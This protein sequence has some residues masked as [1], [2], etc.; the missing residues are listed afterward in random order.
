MRPAIR[1]HQIQQTL[2]STAEIPAQEDLL[3]WLKADAIEGANDGDFLDTWVDSS[4]NARTLS[5]AAVGVNRPRYNTGIIN[6]NPAVHFGHNVGAN[7][8]VP[9]M[10]AHAAGEIMMIVQADADPASS[11]AKSGPDGMNNSAGG[12]SAMPTNFGTLSTRFAS[13]TAHSSIEKPASLSSNFRLISIIS[14]S[15]L[16]RIFYDGTLIYSKEINTVDW[17]V[18]VQ[19]IGRGAGGVNDAWPG[20]IAEMLVWD[21]AL[22]S[23]ERSDGK[24]VLSS[25][26]SLTLTSD[27]SPFTPNDL[28]TNLLG[29]WDASQ[30]TGLSDDDPIDTLPDLSGNGNDWEA[31]GASRPIYKAGIYNSLPTIRFDGTKY[32]G[33]PSFAIGASSAFTFIGVAAADVDGSFLGNSAT[34][35]QVRMRRAGVNNISFYPGAA[36]EAISSVFPHTTG[37]LQMWV[38]RRNSG[39]TYYFMQ[40]GTKSAVV[41]GSSGAFTINR[42]GSQPFGIPFD[43]DACELMCWDR[44]LDDE[45]IYKIFEYHLREK[46]ALPGT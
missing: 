12:D 10:G 32:F 1:S 23:S 5:T 21:R 41:N 36:P 29:W 9:N 46:W 6:G 31:S 4:I 22:T 33:G 11:A 35:V 17:G 19:R 14:E 30:L 3:L 28:S 37:T 44:Q 45:E 27:P 38:W 16:M 20:Y 7:F 13:S 25:K 39:L 18:A 34:N 8:T 24:A 43:G 40:N 2:G 15:G 42:F 26:Y